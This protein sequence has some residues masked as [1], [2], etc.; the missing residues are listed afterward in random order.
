MEKKFPP[1][2]AV[3]KPI[4]HYHHPRVRSFTEH[5]VLSRQTNIVLSLT[6]QHASEVATRN[7]LLFASKQDRNAQEFEID[8]MA[9]IDVA[10]PSS[11]LVIDLAR[12]PLIVTSGVPPVDQTT[13]LTMMG[14]KLS[15]QKRDSKQSHIWMR[16]LCGLTSL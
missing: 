4:L 8:A 12:R 10:T 16:F 7:Q 5:F 6:S 14:N 3:T 13:L 2:A 11:E 1:P 15:Y 9:S